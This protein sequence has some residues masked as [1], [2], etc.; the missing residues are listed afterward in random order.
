MQDGDEMGNVLGQIS[1]QWN[2]HMAK[3]IHAAVVLWQEAQNKGEFC[4]FVQELK[5]N[6]ADRLILGLG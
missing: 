3:R 4:H 2:R 1:S 6:T 5:V